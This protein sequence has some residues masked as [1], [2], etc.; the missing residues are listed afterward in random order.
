MVFATYVVGSMFLLTLSLQSD[1]TVEVGA[2]L[3]EID[4]EAEASYVASDEPAAAA[5]ASPSPAK[6]ETKQQSAAPT[7]PP[8]KKEEAH[9]RTPSIKFLGK[10]G[11][12]QLKAGSGH[13]SPV[14]EQIHPLYG[15][16]PFTQEEVDALVFGGASLEP[17]NVPTVYFLKEF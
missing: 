17:Q 11:W 13:Q 12:A 5:A 10:D 15:R 7:P 16:L 8:Q 4:T 9:H 2:Q 1:E 6:E 3:Y 14:T